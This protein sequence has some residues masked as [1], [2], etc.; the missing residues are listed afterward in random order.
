MDSGLFVAATCEAMSR[1]SVP[2]R[3]TS[4]LLNHGPTT[5]VA[6]AH[7]G[8]TNVMAA[9]WVMPLDFNPPKL[10][11][12]VAADTH[13]RKLVDASGEMVVS[14]P[15]LAQLDLT[16]TVGTLSGADIEDKFTK[17]NIA[18]SKASVVAAPLIDGCLAWME[19]KVLP[20]PEL[21]KDNDLFIV[22][23]VQAWADD[24]VFRDGEWLFG[25]APDA[26]RSIHHVSKGRFFV[27]G[28]RHDAK[29]LE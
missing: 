18:T 26:K 5:L 23:V 3:Q 22:E 17:L 25:T 16:F 2:L 12:V 19:C 8:K 29:L 28:D 7:A 27:I 11:V 14:V 13:T 6:S 1:V 15:S 20:H 10:C 21:Q 9:A 24:E 4:R